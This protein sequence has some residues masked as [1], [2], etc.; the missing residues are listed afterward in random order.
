MQ[1]LSVEATTISEDAAT[2]TEIAEPAP[3]AADNWVMETRERRHFYDNNY[4]AHRG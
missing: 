2:A 4:S 1:E 3:A